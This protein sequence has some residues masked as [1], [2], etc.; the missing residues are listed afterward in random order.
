MDMNYLYQRRGEERLRAVAAACEPSRAAHLDLAD[1]Y[2]GLIHDARAE[3][4]AEAVARRAPRA[5][6]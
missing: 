2:A 5:Q 6:D 1:R 4:G 3:R